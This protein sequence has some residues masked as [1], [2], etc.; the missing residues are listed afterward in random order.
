[1]RLSATAG[2]GLGAFRRLP[3]RNDWRWLW[4]WHV[5]GIWIHQVLQVTLIDGLLDLPL[6]PNK[7]GFTT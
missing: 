7:Q 5:F 2:W 4:D 1:M 3:Q 6:L